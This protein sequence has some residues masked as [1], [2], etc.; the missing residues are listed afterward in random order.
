MH[1]CMYVCAR[2]CVW[3]CMYVSICFYLSTHGLLVVHRTQSLECPAIITAL[4][5][6]SFN[7]IS[8]SCPQPNLAFIVKNKVTWNIV[9]FI[10]FTSPLP[11]IQ[12]IATAIPLT[13]TVSSCNIHHHS[14]VKYLNISSQLLG[15]PITITTLILTRNLS[16]NHIQKLWVETF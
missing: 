10:L 4:W 6:I 9:Y 8:R 1:D 12:H 16:Q 3:V 13:V 14:Q 7:C 5:K 11:Q 2:M 15:L